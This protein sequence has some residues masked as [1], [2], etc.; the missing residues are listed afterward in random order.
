MRTDWIK[1]DDMSLALRLLTPDNALV[2]ETCLVTG[3]RVSD[4]LSINFVQLYKS[5]RIKVLE[6][7]TGKYKTVRLPKKLH[8]KLLDNCGVFYAFEGA[9]NPLRH[10]TRQA[11]WHD[12]K[13]A[14]KALRLKEN[15]APHSARKIYAVQVYREKGLK[16]AQKALNH[17]DASTTL[18]YLLSELIGCEKNG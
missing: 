11:V 10:R 3:L 15:L 6:H 2:V 14:A 8:A 12:V 17:N 5:Q 16:A 9:H 1:H 4:V 18:I 13:R 7:K